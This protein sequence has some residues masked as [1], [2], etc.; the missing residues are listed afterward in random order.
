MNNKLSFAGGIISI[1][2]AGIICAYTIF[3]VLCVIMGLMMLLVDPLI[4]IIILVLFGIC[5]AIS[6]AAIIANMIAGIGA[7]TS[8]FLGKKLNKAFT[9]TT[10]IV[11]ILF[12]CADLM[13]VGIMIFTI[14]ESSSEAPLDF[15]TITLAVTVF[16]SPV[17][18]VANIIINSCA[19]KSHNKTAAPVS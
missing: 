15:I 16:V 7:I 6:V 10:V 9:L 18:A 4:G 12:I 11:D 1:V 17:L 13:W 14:V 19:L 5:T 2:L 8:S 3:L